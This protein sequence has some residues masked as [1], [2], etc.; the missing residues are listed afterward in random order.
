VSGSDLAAAIQNTFGKSVDPS[1]LPPLLLDTIKA[2]AIKLTAAQEQKVKSCMSVSECDLGPGKYSIGDLDGNGQA[3]IRVTHR[4]AVIAQALQYPDI[5][6]IYF[7]DG[8]G[9]LQKFLA[10]FRTLMTR[11]V[12]AIM[13]IWDF[14]SSLKPLATQ[15]TR[16]GILVIPTSQEIPNSDSS[17]IAFDGKI[18]VCAYGKAAA[19]A[20]IDAG[21]TRG[22]VAALYTGVPG[23]TFGAV[24]EPCAKKALEAAGWTVATEGTTN[25]TP[26]GE[27]QAANALIASGKHIDAVIYDY[28]PT[29]MI[30]AYVSAGKQPPTMVGGAGDAGYV[31]AYQAASERYKFTAYIANSQTVIQLLGITGAVEKLQGKSVPLHVIAPDP[32]VNIDAIMPQYNPSLPDAATFNNMLPVD[33]RIAALKG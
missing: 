29:S 16:Q 31:R 20:A 28:T 12:S 1:S 6:K 7:E 18:D 9:D 8:Q 26:Q 30:N 15:A 13:G 5:G 19:Q 2:S 24:Y 33:L 17:T 23:N 21:P 32:I 14:S 11:H 27:Q 25:W 22:G 3:P 4:A 10:G